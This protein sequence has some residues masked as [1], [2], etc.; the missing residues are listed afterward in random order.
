MNVLCFRERQCPIQWW[1]LSIGPVKWHWQSS[2]CWLDWREVSLFELHLRIFKSDRFQLNEFICCLSKFSRND[3]DFFSLWNH[4]EI[5]LDQNRIRLAFPSWC[6]ILHFEVFYA[7]F[8]S[9]S[10]S[11]HV[12]FSKFAG[13]WL[14]FFD[15]VYSC[16]NQFNWNWASFHNQL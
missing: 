13:G 1:W 11:S 6:A 2:E 5:V 12:M 16:T 15:D 9:I 8:Y 3:F 4:W 10:L 7:W 14:Y